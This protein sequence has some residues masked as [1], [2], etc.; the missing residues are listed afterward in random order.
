VALDLDSVGVGTNPGGTVALPGADAFRV[1]FRDDPA[2]VVLALEGEADIA[3]APLLIQA[4]ARASA[5]G[6]APVV[7]DAASLE[8]IDASCVSV[9]VVAADRLREQ[10]RDLVVRSPA[11]LFRRVLSVLDMEDLIEAAPQR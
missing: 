1:V 3:T 2:A 7:L 8:F 5:D 10:G 4:L 11:S 6:A 9:I